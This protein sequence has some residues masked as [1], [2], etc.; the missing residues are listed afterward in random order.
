MVVV[1][2]FTEADAPALAVMMREMARSY[3]AAVAADRDVASEL[4]EQ[5][6]RIEILLAHDGAALLGF[7]TFASL[8]PVG[9]VVA[10]LYVQQLYIGVGGRRS[11]VGRQLMAAVARTAR[12]R[13]CHRLE[14]ATSLDN[15][16]AHAL[17]DSLGAVGVPKLQYALEGGAFDRLAGA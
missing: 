8:F 7:V 4:P 3:G 13:G 15:A 5:A 9:G 17:Y 2:P 6:R 14:W 1:R 12:D 11:G 16:A 10:F